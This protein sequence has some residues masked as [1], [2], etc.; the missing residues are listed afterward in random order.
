MASKQATVSLLLP[1]TSLPTQNVS[2]CIS[3]VQEIEINEDERV[4]RESE[5]SSYCLCDA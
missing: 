2:V 4:E 1:S 3:L 5:K